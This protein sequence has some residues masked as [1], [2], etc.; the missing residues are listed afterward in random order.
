MGDF[1]IVKGAQIKMPE[2]FGP[3]VLVAPPLHTLEATG[4]A[5]IEGAKI[6]QE[7]DEKKVKI[8]TKYTTAIHIKPGEVLLTIAEAKTASYVLSTKPVITA[9]KWTV[10]CAVKI[11]ATDPQG[12]LDPTIPQLQDVFIINNPNQFVTVE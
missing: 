11:P 10:L 12:N 7:N 4:Y 8:T 2:T 1:I 9:Q 6:C 3:I 5:T